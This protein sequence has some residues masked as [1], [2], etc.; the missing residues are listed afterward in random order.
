MINEEILGP[1]KVKDALFFGDHF[2]AKDMEF[3]SNNRITNVINLCSKRVTNMWRHYGV[4][5]L[6]FN[7]PEKESEK[8]IDEKADS[9][10]HIIAYIKEV[11]D[12]GNAILIHSYHGLN[13][14]VL[15]IAA[16]LMES[17]NWNSDKALDYLILKKHTIKLKR[18][19]LQQ[20]KQF[21]E[22]LEKKGRKLSTS[23]TPKST[24]P[25]KIDEEV[26]L[27]NTYINS[28]MVRESFNHNKKSPSGEGARKVNWPKK[29]WK[30]IPNRRLSVRSSVSTQPKGQSPAKF[31]LPGPTPTASV[32]QKQKNNYFVPPAQPQPATLNSMIDL[33]GTG[34]SL[35]QQR[36]TKSELPWTAKDHKLKK[37]PRSSSNNSRGVKRNNNTESSIAYIERL[38]ST[39]DGGVNRASGLGFFKKKNKRLVKEINGMNERRVEQKSNMFAIRKPVLVKKTD[40]NSDGLIIRKEPPEMPDNTRRFKERQ[41]QSQKRQ[42][43]V[44]NN[45]N[46]QGLRIKLR[47]NSVK[48][49]DQEDNSTGKKGMLYSNVRFQGGIVGKTF[50]IGF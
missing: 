23:W 20:L 10:L 41:S 32:P 37:K 34:S 47:P 44:S 3:L 28:K 25:G 2:A 8:L 40:D 48:P 27:T 18:G 16:F 12:A 14:S 6:S 50:G 21:E 39:T 19:Y 24:P 4:S 33:S 13:R 1:V 29:L 22:V 49:L 38:Y 15:V 30:L 46:T 42:K 45:H 9:I 36:L 31:R 26:I 5:Y 17:Y 43:R 11:L 7:W 35:N